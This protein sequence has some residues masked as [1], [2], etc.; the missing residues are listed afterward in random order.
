MLYLDWEPVLVFSSRSQ[1]CHVP[2]FLERHPDGALCWIFM[3]GHIIFVCP[4]MGHV[5][6]IQFQSLLTLLCPY[7]IFPNILAVILVLGRGL[8][9]IPKAL[10]VSYAVPL[11]GAGPGRSSSNERGAAMMPYPGSAILP[12]HMGLGMQ[13]PL[14]EGLMLLAVDRQ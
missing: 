13:A 3:S 2:N 8:L 6:L 4:S 12:L 5:T 9:A 14:C 10:S 7:Y 1:F 11:V